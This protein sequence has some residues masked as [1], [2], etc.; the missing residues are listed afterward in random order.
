MIEDK[1]AWGLYNY[2]DMFS[3]E[4]WFDAFF[5]SMFVFMFPLFDLIDIGVKVGEG[6]LTESGEEK[7]PA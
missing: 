1:G 7:V 5:L 2:F 4:G 6:K 3:V